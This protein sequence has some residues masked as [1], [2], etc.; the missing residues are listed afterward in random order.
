MRL[1]LREMISEDRDERNEALFYIDTV[2]AN[3]LFSSTIKPAWDEMMSRL[4]DTG[5]G[6]DLAKALSRGNLKTLLDAMAAGSF[7]GNAVKDFF[8]CGDKPIG[9]EDRKRVENMASIIGID[10]DQAIKQVR[11]A[12]Q[13]ITGLINRGKMLKIIEES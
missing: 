5:M 3:P 11:A 1:L 4:S 13:Q 2:E 8:E 12:D 7:A 10:G 6:K 9:E